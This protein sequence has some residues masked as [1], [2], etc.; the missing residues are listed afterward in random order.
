MGPKLKLPVHE[1]FLALL[2]PRRYAR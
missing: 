2:D 1:F